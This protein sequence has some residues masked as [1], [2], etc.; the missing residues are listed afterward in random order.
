MKKRIFALAL[1]LCMMLSAMPTSFAGNGFLTLDGQENV[2]EQPREQQQEGILTLDDPDAVITQEPEEEPVYGVLTPD[3]PS[4]EPKAPVVEQS[5]GVLYVEC[6]EC[7]YLDGYH[8]DDCPTI[9]P[10]EQEPVRQ[11]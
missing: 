5:E 11:P 7:G 9:Q 10:E 3:T 1:A 6:P 8:A 2:E 4:E